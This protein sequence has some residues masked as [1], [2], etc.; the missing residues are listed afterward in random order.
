MRSKFTN[1]AVSAVLT[2]SAVLLTLCSGQ[3]TQDMRSALYRCI[4]VIIPSLFAFMAAADLIIKSG[5]YISVSRLLTPLTHL[6]G[7]PKSA[8]AVFLIS[9]T[10]GFPV[11]ASMISAMFDNGNIDKKSASRLICTCYGGGPA[12]FCSAVGLAVFGSAKIGMMIF[13]SGILAN[14]IL[15]VVVFR[16]FPVELKDSRTKQH[17]SAD[18]LPDSVSSA[19]RS[20]FRICGMILFFQAVMSLLSPI[21][22]R[23]ALTD[24]TRQAVMAFMEI[25]A[26]SGVEGTP[27]RLLPLMAAAGAFGGVC[28]VMQTAVIVG[29]RFSLRPFLAARAAAAALSAGIMKIMWEL[30][31]TAAV[32][33]STKPI[34][35]VNFN[36]FIPS[37]CLIIMIFLTI[38]RKG[39]A[40]SDRM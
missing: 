25:S 29:G 12:F 33:A 5:A 39:V 23:L 9:N 30:F 4:N 10:A 14:M 35:L 7:L 26:L 36:N 24:S 34:F 19:G 37:V 38:L 40:F 2:F 18:M 8:G 3:V 32:T 1:A 13:L 21:F 15:S 20:L 22:A 28:V 17:F 6:L 16:L 31:G 11:G 27:Y